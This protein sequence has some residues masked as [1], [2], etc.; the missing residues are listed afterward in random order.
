MPYILLLRG[1]ENRSLNRGLR[2]I[3]VRYT[4]VHSLYLPIQVSLW[5][6]HNKEIYKECRAVC[7]IVSFRGQFMLNPLNPEI[8]IKIL[9]CRPYSFTTEVL[10]NS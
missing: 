1:K 5:A 10:R 3:E 2:Y 9:I 4:E 7:S 6:V 8:K